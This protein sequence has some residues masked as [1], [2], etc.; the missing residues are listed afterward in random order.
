MRAWTAAF[1]AAATL[2]NAEDIWAHRFPLRPG[3]EVGVLATAYCQKGRTESG[4]RTAAN[5][6]AADPRVLPAGSTVRML[7]GPRRGIYTVMDTGAAI[8]GLKIDIFISDC[9]QAATFG[10]QRIRIRVLRNRIV[11]FR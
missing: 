7:D 6:I 9:G 3:S 5:I 2:L 11:T 10:K 8:K 4:A 1:V